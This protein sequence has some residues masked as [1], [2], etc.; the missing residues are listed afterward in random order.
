MDLVPTSGS[1]DMLSEGKARAVLR[2]A[3]EIEV[4]GGLSAAELMRAGTEAGIDPEAL[5]RALDE[6][7]GGGA[8]GVSEPADPG[9]IDAGAQRGPGT[10]RI[11][12]PLAA[13]GTALGIVA[14]GLSE[15]TNP[16][17]LVLAHWALVFT[18][19]FAAFR[20]RRSGS[21]EG[22]QAGVFGL[23]FAFLTASSLIAGG[24]DPELLIMDGLLWLCAVVVGLLVIRGRRGRDGT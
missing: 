16:G 22:Y 12:A 20:A 19:L 14:G 9:P 11:A 18:S 8:A 17:W 24:V 2:R 21:Q 1:R 5:E 13:L 7:S 15:A 3:L 6:L 4:S 10:W 23:W